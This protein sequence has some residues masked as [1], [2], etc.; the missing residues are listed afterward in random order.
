MPEDKTWRKKHGK[1]GKAPRL[2]KQ[3]FLGKSLEIMKWQEVK[4]GVGEEGLCDQHASIVN[5]L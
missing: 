5:P 1:I 4:G 3:R 2:L